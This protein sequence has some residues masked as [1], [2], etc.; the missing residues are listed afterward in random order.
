MIMYEV[1]TNA[2]EGMAH[3]VSM[4]WD[5]P[6]EIETRI[7]GVG[8]KEGMDI[9]PWPPGV[10]GLE[11]KHCVQAIYDTGFT[12]ARRPITKPGYCP[13]LYA[14]LFLQNRQIGYMKWRPILPRKVNGGGNSRRTTDLVPNPTVALLRSDAGDQTGPKVVGDTTGTLVDPADPRRTI[15]YT[16]FNQPIPFLDIWSAM[17]SALA[18]AAPYGVYETGAAV[19]AAGV[20]GET[21]LHMHQTGVPPLLNWSM[22]INAV[23]MIWNAIVNNHWHRAIDFDL[24]YDGVTVGEGY[25]WNIRT[26]RASRKSL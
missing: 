14:G 11:V 25:I 4:P 3:F 2:V 5:A 15:K 16:V 8:Y 18:T 1:F 22:V 6:V 10:R 19:D 12:L 9:S 23:R 20:S 17:L 13:K 26:T 24:T 7:T 21:I